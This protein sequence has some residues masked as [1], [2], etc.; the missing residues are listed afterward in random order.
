MGQHG[1]TK[2]GDRQLAP[3]LGGSLDP[4]QALRGLAFWFVMISYAALRPGQSGQLSGPAE[5]HGYR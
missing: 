1:I 4:M 2:P 5:R 3:G